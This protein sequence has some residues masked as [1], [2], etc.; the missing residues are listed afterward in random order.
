L[1]ITS[2]R[3][4]VSFDPLISFALHRDL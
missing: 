4:S 2:A 1:K 3:K